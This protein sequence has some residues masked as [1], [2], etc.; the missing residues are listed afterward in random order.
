VTRTYLAVGCFG[1]ALISAV[2]VVAISQATVIPMVARGS[3]PTGI[4]VTSSGW[5]ALLTSLAS[6]GGFTIAGIVAALANRFGV[7]LRDTSTESLIAEVL[8]LTASFA[9]LMSN[10][11]NRAYQRRFFFALVDAASLIQGCEASHD[12]GVII[13][14]YHGYADQSNPSQQGESA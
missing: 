10:K 14:K 3:G 11:S 6:T 1:V 12:G 4:Q 8:E 2:A 5:L 7:R 9:A 13:L